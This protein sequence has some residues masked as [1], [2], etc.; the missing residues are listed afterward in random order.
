MSHRR[1][2]SLWVENVSMNAMRMVFR[3]PGSFP[4]HGR[5]STPTR[6]S[7]TCIAYASYSLESQDPAA[8]AQAA[9]VRGDVAKGRRLALPRR[10]RQ[11]WGRAAPGTAGAV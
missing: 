10:R 1:Y 9:A 8:G 2:T 5:E 11:W 3:Q 7:R 6:A 4:P